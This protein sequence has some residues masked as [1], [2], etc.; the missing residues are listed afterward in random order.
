LKI[1]SAESGFRESILFLFINFILSAFL[2]FG[3]STETEQVLA[4]EVSVA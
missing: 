1:G 2:D 4:L 3:F